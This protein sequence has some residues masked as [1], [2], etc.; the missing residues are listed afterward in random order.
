MSYSASPPLAPA[1][2]SKVV[3][4]SSVMLAFIS[5]WQA[6][7]IVLNSLASSAFYA[8]GIA[9]QAVGK[10]APWL[11][12]A[13]MLLCLAIRTVYVESS[14]MFVRGGVYREVKDALGGPLA[15]ISVSVLLFDYLLTGPISGVAAG[16]YIGG[17]I[18]EL[19]AMGYSHGVW[20]FVSMG[21]SARPP[22]IP[23]NGV[24]VVI[25]VSATLYYWR[26]NVKGIGESSGKAL[27]VIRLTTIMAVILLVWAG[28]TLLKQPFQVPPSLRPRNLVFSAEALGFLKHSQIPRLFGMLGL[29]IAFGHAMIAM[30]GIES[31]AQVY[32]EIRHPKLQNLRRCALGVTVYAFVLT[33]AVSLLSVM[34]IPDSVRISQYRDN[35]IGG[36]AMYL[37]GP[38][39]LKL[40]FRIFV[41]LVGFLILS[42]GINTSIM[43]GNGVLHR[44]SEDG[45]LTA[46]FREPHKN[47]GTNYRIISMVAGI[48]LFFILISGGDVYILGEAYVFGV[49][50]SF[51]FKALTTMVTRLRR[52]RWGDD[53]AW[54]V[55]LN[56]TI[57]S[58][59][60]P[61]GL[62]CIC[63]V[64]LITAIVNLF[65]K[66][67]ATISGMSFAAVLCGIFTL[68]ERINRRKVF[69]NDEQLNES[70]I[71]REC[72]HE[73]QSA[74]NVKSGNILV[75]IRDT[76]PSKSL[77]WVLEQEW[78]ENRDIVAVAVH[79][80]GMKTPEDLAVDQILTPIERVVLSQSVVSAESYGKPISLLVLPAANVWTGAIETAVRLNS[81]ALVFGLSSK[82]SSDEQAYR[83]GVAWEAAPEPKQKLIVHVVW[84]DGTVATYRIGP[85]ELTL[86]SHDVHLVHKLWMKL[87]KVAGMAEVR[88]S[89][90]VSVA[91]E[92]LS[93]D[94][95]IDKESVL[96][97]LKKALALAGDSAELKRRDEDTKLDN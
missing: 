71:V 63:L 65:T 58:K 6:A 39:T 70:F 94:Y 16:Q 93:R 66:S 33:S 68:S 2:R 32:R 34:L 64:L 30:S 3:V 51:T 19:L 5:P 40:L 25:A 85:H 83:L 80:T 22:Q 59:K 86:N 13:V 26:E 11:V 38:Q 87:Q 9:E 96:K 57:E 72:D 17:L 50:W 18:N 31:L 78:N 10:A 62:I 48:Q 21:S 27:R 23:L 82:M 43:A 35:L 97:D 90:I 36:L 41:V 28:L 74:L 84:P 95:A 14:S 29:I 24:A 61:V 47:F 20:P 77:Q 49:I 54:K 45:I 8:A 46:W 73:V 91:L 12:M 1:N 15:K 76:Y 81:S 7:A 92:R 55:P 4:A 67:I 89:H 88:H 37:W 69:E 60:I 52:Q 44:L 42:G 53:P 75:F 79:P 56:L